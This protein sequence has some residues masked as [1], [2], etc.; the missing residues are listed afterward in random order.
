MR[1]FGQIL[2]MTILLS[3][4]ASAQNKGM[5]SAGI[6]GLRES[7]EAIAATIYNDVSSLSPGC[8]SKCGRTPRAPQDCADAYADLYSKPVVTM[9]V[10]LGYMDRLYDFGKNSF[11]GAEDSI[12]REVLQ[13]ELTTPCYRFPD[14]SVAP[15]ACGFK[16]KS[17]DDADLLTKT[18]TGPDG[19]SHVV[20][21]H[22]THSSVSFSDI[23][24]RTALKVQ[25]DQVQTPLAERNFYGGAGS[26]DVWISIG[27][28]RKGGGTTHS[29]PPLKRGT[30]AVSYAAFV[31]RAPEM[32]LL[33]AL[34]ENPNPPKIVARFACDSAGSS[35]REMLEATRGRS[36][37]VTSVG[38]VEPEV[39]Y[40]QMM[41]TLDSVLAMR[42]A[43]EF[44]LALNSVKDFSYDATVHKRGKGTRR[45][46]FFGGPHPRFHFT[47]DEPDVPLR[48]RSQTPLND[49]S[50]HP[51]G[52]LPA[53]PATG[54][55]GTDAVK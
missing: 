37:V 44:D 26:A 55:Q 10:N 38:L 41:A 23:Q 51:T 32:R 54:V 34:R 19:Q 46:G 15:G 20:E 43:N 29:P 11:I 47:D 53:N 17:L 2:V 35:E 6:E 8:F 28:D 4:H 39:A 16:Q 48:M 31:D 3:I 18:L 36:G 1:A 5:I 27:H 24:N 49:Q 50:I 33:T 52:D 13:K 45:Q 7:S 14:G 30:L 12:R 25:Q 42:C 40:A 22:L 9:S 21:L